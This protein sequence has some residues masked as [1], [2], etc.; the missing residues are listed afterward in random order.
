VGHRPRGGG[1]GGSVR[2]L[3]PGETPLEGAHWLSGSRSALASLQGGSVAGDY[4]AGADSPVSA[5]WP[6]HISGQAVTRGIVGHNRPVGRG[7]G[8][9]ARRSGLS[10]EPLACPR[11]TQLVRRPSPCFGG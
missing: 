4:I 7:S 5:N 9:F 1:T 2:V 8:R 10:G 6:L 11:R 3:G